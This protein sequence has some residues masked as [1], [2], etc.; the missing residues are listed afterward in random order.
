VWIVTIRLKKKERKKNSSWVRRREGSRG[1][2]PRGGGGGAQG[3]GGVRKK[4]TC[5]DG[6]SNKNNRSMTSVGR[7]KTSNKRENKRREELGLVLR[8]WGF[9]N[10]R[11]IIKGQ[12]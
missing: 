7:K 4:K 8:P 10:G 12:S 2:G 3:L 1:C 9:K 6:L 5:R 11:R